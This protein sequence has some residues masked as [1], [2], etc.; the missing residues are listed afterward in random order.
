MEDR[1]F[2]TFSI[3]CRIYLRKITGQLFA[4]VIFFYKGE[5]A[6]EIKVAIIGGSGLDDPEFMK[7]MVEQEV[8][9]PYGRPSSPLLTGRVNGVDTVVL[10]RHGRGHAI[11]PTAVNYRANIHALK[12]AG[13]TH[14]L[15]TTAVGSL[16]EQI[17]PGDL[18]FPDQF[19]DFTKHR[20]LTFHEDEVVHTSMAEPFC[21]QLSLK[22]AAE[23]RGLALAF[24]D[25][26]TVVTIEGPRFST[27]AE[28]HMFR[29][30]GA[31]VINMSTVPEVTL[32]REAG[33][34]YQ[35]IAMSTDYDS[36]KEGEEPVTWEMI[37][38]TMRKNADNVKKLL[39]MVLPK[40]GPER[41]CEN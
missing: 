8:Q 35:A 17:R 1:A 22:L 4:E 6:V 16:R 24:H 21:R 41:C 3:I 20:V 23:A 15:A 18:V 14:V 25:R 34:C 11:Y 40:I 26:G 13:C 30:L 38:A 39:H 10:A 27:R 5:E 2:L 36:W 19:I 31:D 33:L 9:T 29:M 32:A 37:I 28:S 12:A 7:D